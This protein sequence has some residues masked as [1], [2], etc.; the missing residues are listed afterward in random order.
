MGFMTPTPNRT[1]QKHERN[2]QP[3]NR[4]FPEN[5]TPPEKVDSTQL[6]LIV[7]QFGTSGGE[8]RVRR[9]LKAGCEGVAKRTPAPIPPSAGRKIAPAAWSV[10]TISLAFAVFTGAGPLSASAR[11]MVFGASPVRSAKSRT[12]MFTRPRAARSCAPVGWSA[13]F[14]RGMLMDSI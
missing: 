7:D 5:V 1:A 12:D 9:R 13:G 8:T 14:V 11:L 2:Q 3:L 4:A 6:R 10:A